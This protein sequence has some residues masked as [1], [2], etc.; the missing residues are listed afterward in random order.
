[1]SRIFTRS[2]YIVEI[3]ETGQESTRLEL[4]IW[5]EGTTEPTSPQYNLS[6]NI[7]ASNLPSTTYNVSPY[8]REYISFDGYTVNVSDTPEDTDTDF[9]TNVRIKSFYTTA[10]SESEYSNTIHKAFDGYG[11][12]EEGYNPSLG[13]TTVLL[14]EGTYYYDENTHAGSINMNLADIQEY[15]KYTNL[16]DGTEINVSFSTNELRSYNRVHTDNIADGNKLEL[17]RG[18]NVLWTGYFKPQCELK[19]TPV[20]I[21]YVNRFGMWA[22]TFM[23]K[24]SKDTFST[25][26]SE[27]NLMQ[28]DLVNYSVLEGQRKQFNVNGQESIKV[29]S[30]WVREDYANELKQLLVSERILVNNRPAKCMTTSLDM[31]KSIN[32]NTISYSLDF[33]F[34]NDYINSVV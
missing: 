18:L 31:Q 16:N 12:Y 6:K 34:N 33:Q 24:T 13:S 11:T 22:I 28:S 10:L 21:D 2:P 23:F 30:G 29:N 15:V 32:D 5:K 4:Y 25:T 3:N 27:Y 8:I 17:Y 1:M 7:P 19:Y 14:D 9:Y 20:Y 26:S